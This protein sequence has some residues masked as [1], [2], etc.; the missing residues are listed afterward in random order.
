MR[1][2]LQDITL[3][4]GLPNDWVQSQDVPCPTCRYNLRMLREPRCAECGLIF[5]WQAV[6]R[7]HCPRCNESLE[8]TNAN[9][10]PH[11]RLE[12]NWTRLLDDAGAIDRTLFEY[13]DHPMRAAIRTMCAALRPGRFWR[14]FPIEAPPVVVRLRWLQRVAW[15]AILLGLLLTGALRGWAGLVSYGGLDLDELTS[16]IVP[17]LALLA[18]PI[19]TPPLVTWLTMPL[20]WPTLGL[21]RVRPDQLLRLRALSGIGLLWLAAWFAAALVYAV[22]VNLAYNG[23]AY[24]QYGGMRLPLVV[25]ADLIATALMFNFARVLREIP[26]QPVLYNAA[27]TYL[28]VALSFGWWWLFLYA[29]LRRY[30]RLNRRNAVALFLSTQI[31]ALLLELV[32][33]LQLIIR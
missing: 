24:P 30:L 17:T 31:P 22:I 11:C 25:D 12:L 21:F 29:G 18:I 28:V 8:G 27:A 6:L 3:P 32:L 4:D 10:C 14:R 13:S 26:L 16:E 7:V 23:V 20:F 5:R 33:Q 19:L 2:S 1:G 15:A 9:T